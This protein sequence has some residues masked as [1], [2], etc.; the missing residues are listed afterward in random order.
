LSASR[1]GVYLRPAVAV[2]IKLDELNRMDANAFT[3]ALGQVFEHAPWVA[4]RAAA[5]RPFTGRA[6]LH[7]AMVRAVQAASHGEQMDLIC[8]HPELA[9]KAAVALTADSA[10]EQR[11]AGLDRLTQAEYEQFHALNAAYRAKFGFPFIMAV[12]G[13]GKEEILESFAS[14]LRCTRE[15]EFATALEQIGRIAGFRL[16]DLVAE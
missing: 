14:R 15:A 7:E 4:A 9:G 2:P 5:A 6:A 3:A 13:R 11:G 12:K 8:G 1:F 16:A 10:R